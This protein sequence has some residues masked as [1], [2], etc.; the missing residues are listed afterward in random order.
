M[1]DSDALGAPPPRLRAAIA[2]DL[3]PVV[4]LPPPFAR[5]IS[6]VPLAVLL[7]VAAPLTFEFRT[8]L[9]RLGWTL[10][11]GLSI[12][13]I[14]IG[15]AVIGAALRDAIP[16]RSWSRAAFAGWL[17]LAIVA[18]LAITLA[19][20]EASPIRLRGPWWGVTA[21]CLIGSA[22]GALP[23]VA[24]G[25]VLA[26]RAWPTRPAI[27]G[28]LIG[29]GAGLLSDAGWRLFCHFSEPTHVLA[30]HLGGVAIAVVFGAVLTR[31]LAEGALTSFAR[32]R[33][34]APKAFGR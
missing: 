24:L 31:G 1:S 23:A 3:A 15:L 2:R 9:A 6:M 4:P 33:R 22:A 7:L 29:L 27:V 17:A 8:D 26:A 16:G 30:G 12:A 28:V 21:L 11:W 13:Q 25:S 14:L 32:R 34:F 20:W 5:T 19:S 18:F 10:A